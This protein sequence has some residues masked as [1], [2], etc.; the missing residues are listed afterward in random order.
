MMTAPK[1][2]ET[3]SLQTK[4]VE[5]A[6]FTFMLLASA[7]LHELHRF[8]AHGHMNSHVDINKGIVFTISSEEGF[9]N[10]YLPNTLC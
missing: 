10:C 8:A 5:N 9:Y 1:T 4:Q 6:C 2:I 3:I 7:G